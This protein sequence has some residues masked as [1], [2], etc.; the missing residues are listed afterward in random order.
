M[1]GCCISAE[2]RENQRI[3]EEIEKQLRKDKKDSR[4]ELK[5][6]LLGGHHLSPHLKLA[7]SHA[8]P[9]LFQP[10]VSESYRRETRACPHHRLLCPFNMKP[11]ELPKGSRYIKGVGL[12][13]F[14]LFIHVLFIYFFVSGAISNIAGHK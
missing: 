12:K 7:P 5:L 3:S 2:D 4:R 6:L 14:S 10:P 1:A 11:A 9:V 8:P 13:T